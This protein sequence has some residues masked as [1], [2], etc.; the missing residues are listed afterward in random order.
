M[1]V[2]GSHRPTSLKVG[3]GLHRLHTLLL[4]SSFVFWRFLRWRFAEWI[5]PLMVPV[6]NGLWFLRDQS[7]NSPRVLKTKI[8]HCGRRLISSMLQLSS[9]IRYLPG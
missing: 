9:D 1:G 7:F 4:F 2:K 5:G 8:G 6:R 3:D